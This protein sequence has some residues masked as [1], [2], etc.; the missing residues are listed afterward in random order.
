MGKILYGVMGD[1]FG[2]VSRAL[3]VTKELSRHEV[4]FVG[5]GRVLELRSM[6]YHVE[7][8]PVFG[9]YYS[10]NRVAFTDTCLNG[11]KILTGQARII[12]RVSDLIRDFAPD[13]VLTDYEYFLPLAARQVG[14]PC[15]SLDHQHF[16]TKCACTIPH[17]EM[18]S[19]L[20][21]LTAVTWF[22]SNADRYLVNSFFMLPPLNPEETEVFPPVLRREVNH[23]VPTDGDHVLVYQTST[24][25]GRLFP[26]LQETSNRY[27]IYGFGARPASGLL[28]YKETS[29]ES[30]LE[31]LASSRYVIVNG[32]HN[33]ISEALY[34]GKPVLSFPIGLAYEQFY[35][36][37]M[38]R[39][40]GYGDYST[41]Q[42][43]DIS[44][45]GRFEARLD[46][47]R[48]EIAEGHFYGNEKLARRLE[49]MI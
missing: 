38:L 48:R 11:L 16:L 39:A 26:V 41:N 6:G 35:N 28:E 43:P 42:R 36:A 37:Y 31:D 17:G 8:V 34:Y 47:F 1:S 4:L 5:G 20:M 3:A 9:T 12:R 25:F 18:V 24:T 27:V 15:I 2:H 40:L 32:G 49:E 19:R 46:L 23:F 10:N 21:L 13:L 14:I 45:L 33:A 44:I 7:Q 30:F 29:S 22:F